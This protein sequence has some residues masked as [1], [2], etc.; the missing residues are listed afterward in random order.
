MVI[1]QCLQ[2]SACRLYLGLGTDS[3]CNSIPHL[4]VT[5]SRAF[6]MSIESCRISI[7]R[8]DN[9]E[10]HLWGNQASG[11]AEGFLLPV[12]RLCAA[13]QPRDFASRETFLVSRKA[14]TLHTR[15]PPHLRQRN[16]TL[17]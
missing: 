15:K 9:A 14:W 16:I 2:N 17:H 8:P 4:I 6:R 5:Y 13:L 11:F 3:N 7:S 10:Y 1:P 12:R